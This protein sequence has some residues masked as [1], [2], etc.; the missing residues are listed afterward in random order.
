M[1]PAV[2]SDFAP[3]GSRLG[4]LHVVRLVVVAVVVAVTSGVPQVV[5]AD[6]RA[7]ASVTALYVL[8]AVGAELL[9]GGRRFPGAALVGVMLLLDG[10]YLGAVVA[11]TGGAGSVLGFLVVIHVIAVTLL[12]SFRT[13]LKIALWH[14]LL[15]FVTYN[16]EAAGLLLADRPVVGPDEAAVFSSLA[17]LL[18]AAGTAWFSSLNEVELRRGK[19]ELGALADMGARMQGCRQ[20]EELAQVL[21]ET[22]SATFAFPRAA[23]LLLDG[24]R[25]RALVLSA[26]RQVDQVGWQRRPDRVAAECWA[27]RSPVLVR[28]LD[29]Q[30]DP[31]LHAALPGAGNVVVVPL[32][33]DGRPLGALAVERGGR[34][35]AR[36]AG[37]TV[38]MV[39]Q[40]A[41]VA[42]LALRSA[43]LLGEVERLA[44][45]DALTGL[46]NRRVFHEALERELAM[47]ARRGEPCTLV[48]LDVD[49]FKAVN[50]THGHPAGDDVLRHVGRTLAGAARGTDLASRYGGE[51]F[52]LILPTCSA[53]ESIGVAERLRA[54]IAAESGPVPVT[55]SAGVA[56][57]PLHGG[58]G[59]SL[60]AAADEALYRA[61]RAGRDRSARSRR[62]PGGGHL[63]ALVGDVA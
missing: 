39:A 46:A 63:A 54:A 38:A 16:A 6:G 45:T 33:A 56:T 36:I 18:V 53:A 60:V 34:G 29:R 44:R 1:T 28:A 26:S 19:G 21:L 17:V 2:A 59:E 35:G 15:L 11:L 48:V 62:R 55:V 24:E 49:R 42:A 40:F 32:V 4:L 50:D 47:A 12:V 31:Q 51:E 27:R 25:G 10:V 7:L 14:A 22:V 41:A 30:A 61:K 8:V 57:Y 23:V 37:R 13:G 3:L 43:S 5:G 9:R 52:A 20:P 58:D